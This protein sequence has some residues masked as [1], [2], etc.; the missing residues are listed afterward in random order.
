[1][2]SD[3]SNCATFNPTLGQLIANKVISIQVFVFLMLKLA[4]AVQECDATEANFIAAA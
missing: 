3:N 1:M 4:D 2:E